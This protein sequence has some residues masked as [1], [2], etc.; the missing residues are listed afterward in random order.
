M[1]ARWV[2][3]EG[4]PEQIADAC[5]AHLAAGGRVDVWAEL[6]GEWRTAPE[7]AR[8]NFVGGVYALARFALVYSDPPQP[9]RPTIEASEALALV[10]EHGIA[11]IDE[12]IVWDWSPAQPARVDPPEGVTVPSP[13]VPETIT[14]TLTA[15][16]VRQLD[17]D[18][19]GSAVPVLE[20][21]YA[22]AR[23]A[24]LLPLDGTDGD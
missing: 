4:T 2:E 10:R 19:P 6:Q 13:P 21:V 1:T 3:P 24:G 5:V 7:W 20:A 12:A 18:G 11:H 16:A 9:E 23:D 14:V 17:D 22:A 15:D 8:V